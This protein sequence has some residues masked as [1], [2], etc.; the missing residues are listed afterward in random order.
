MLFTKTF[1]KA[2]SLVYIVPT[3]LL[4]TLHYDVHGGLSSITKGFDGTEEISAEFFTV[5]SKS[6]VVPCVINAKGGTTK[7]W[8]V[9]YSEEFT[10]PMAYLPMGE[11]ERIINDITAG[12]CNRY[13]FYVG[14]VDSGAAPIINPTALNTWA[15][16]NHFE[17]LPTWLVP[18][19]ANDSTLE[20]FISTNRNFPFKYPLISGFIIYQDGGF[21]VFKLTNLKECLVTKTKS[22]VSDNGYVMYEVFYQNGDATRSIS[23]HY[24]DA[25]RFNI[26]KTSQIILDGDTV[27]WSNSR[28]KGSTRTPLSSTTTC[29]YCG[30]LLPVPNIGPM[31]CTDLHCTSLLYPRVQRFCSVL[32]LACIAKSTFD[33][34]I[35]SD[36][37][38]TLPDL[39][40]LPTYKK[41]SIN[42]SLCDIIF[43]VISGDVGLDKQWL[44]K[45]CGHCNNN[46][47]TIKYY[48]EN[49]IK[50]RT[51]LDM[52]VPRRL[53]S[54]LADP[55][56]I[57]ELDTIINSEQV[58]IEAISKIRKFDGPNLFRG[59]TIYITGTFMHG[60]YEDI[61]AILS[62][63]GAVVVTEFDE[64]VQCVLI[65]DI[66]DGIDGGAI[67]SA[68]L[69]KIPTFEETAFFSRYDIDS[70]LE[71]YLL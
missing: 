30:K 62:S 35:A 17:T 13:K 46:Y 8:G 2:G 23:I 38:R 3:G 54:W 21:P 10:N 57:L 26:Q 40:L 56:N 53:I 70:D 27:V 24:S 39:L 37:L 48:L 68:R 12:N 55:Q 61:V 42:N 28:G 51:E 6:G 34:Y 4:V 15:R 20:A 11:Y 5:V 66:K 32:G 16:T 69:L 36:D 29:N 41:L 47:K 59:K 64:Y 60:S 49:P 31:T 19:D 44:S 63:Y 33:K 43:A 7:I 67:Q 1:C 58:D 45:L 71:K 14:N 9:F 22:F 50:M 65:G 52:E 18:M 25:V